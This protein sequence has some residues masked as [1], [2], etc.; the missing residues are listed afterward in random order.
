MPLPTSSVGSLTCCGR[1][2]GCTYR[3]G[4]GGEGWRV[5]GMIT[6]TDELFRHKINKIL[7]RC[8]FLSY[9]SSEPGELH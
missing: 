3:V 9:I 6:I 8:T 1:L 7:F 5:K 4:G 2:T